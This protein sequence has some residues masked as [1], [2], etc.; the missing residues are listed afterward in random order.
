MKQ[1]LLSEKEWSLRQ[2]KNRA[3]LFA[4]QEEESQHKEWKN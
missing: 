2:E 1:F 3:V 4:K